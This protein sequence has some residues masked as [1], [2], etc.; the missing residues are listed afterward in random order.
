[1]SVLSSG[2]SV[3]WLQ[4]FRPVYWP[5]NPLTMW[6]SRSLRGHRTVSVRHYATASVGGDAPLAP[7]KLYVIA[8]EASGDAIGAKAIRA[9][10]RRRPPQTLAFRGIGGC[11]NVED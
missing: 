3:A 2:S 11:V 9:L 8:G 1:V 5:L 4:S 7:L 10:Q 6:R